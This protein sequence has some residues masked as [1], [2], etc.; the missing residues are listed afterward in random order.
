MTT[1]TSR[2]WRRLGYAL[3]F[4]AMLG[5]GSTHAVDLWDAAS[6]FQYNI[7]K[8]G[9]TALATVPPSYSVKVVFSVTD[10]KLSDTPWDIKN[11]LPF[12]SAG[13]QLTL[14]IGWDPGSDFTN[15]GSRGGT[16]TP[17]TALGDAPAA[18]VQVRSLTSK[19]AGTARECTVADCGPTGLNRYFAVATITPLPFPAGAKSGRVALEGRPVCNGVPGVSCPP[20]APPPATPYL[21]VPA[22]SAM[23]NF[24]LAPTAPLAAMTADPRRAVVDINKCMTCHNDADHGTGFVPRLSLHGANRNENLGVCVICHNANQTDV[25]YR[26]ATIAG[27]DPRIGGLEVPIDFKTMVHSIHAG[28]FREKP[29]VVIG[30]SSSVNDFS[31]VRFPRELRDCTSCHLDANGRGTFE[32]PLRTGVLGTTVKTMS[33]YLSTP[34]S[35]DVNPANDVKISPIAAVCSSCHDKAEVKSHMVKT[36]GASFATTQAAIG[37]TVR[38]R[39][40]SCHGPGQD[41]DVRRAH[42]IGRSG[43]DSHDD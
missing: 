43:D 24:T 30:R 1:S 32:L 23:V 36:G 2:A 34:R 4:G 8:V 7:E 11:A 27:E 39:C 15:T 40:A 28:G 33:S 5:A 29:F 37:T 19:T 16:F 25:A 26:R 6:H 3:S 21:N 35:I 38:E 12:Q 13:A 10:P 20:P 17:L 14:D 41:K 18:P 42:E 22:R 31:D 9:V